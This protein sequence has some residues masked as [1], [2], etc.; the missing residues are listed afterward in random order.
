MEKKKRFTIISLLIA[1]AIISILMI[2]SIIAERNEIINRTKDLIVTTR[3]NHACKHLIADQADGKLEKGTAFKVNGRYFVYNGETPVETPS[4]PDTIEAVTLVRIKKDKAIAFLFQSDTDEAM[5]ENSGTIA[6]E[7]LVDPDEGSF[8]V[9]EYSQVNE[10]VEKYLEQVSYESTP[11]NVSY[12]KN[13]LQ[14]DKRY[15]LPL[16]LTIELLEGELTVIDNCTQNKY[17]TTVEKGPYTFYNITP[18]VGGEFYI[19]HEDKIVQRGHLRP[20][21]ALRMIYSDTPG[22]QNMRDLG[23]WP[24]DGGTIKYNILFRGGTVIDANDTDRNTWV[25]MLGIQHDV[26]LKTYDESQ[27]EGKEQYRNKSPLGD[28]VSFYQNDLTSPGSENK[29]NFEQAKDEMNGIINRIFDNAIAGEATYFHCLAGADRTGMVAVI[30][31][32]VLGVPLHEIDRDYELTSFSSVRERTE[33][34]YS[35]DIRILQKYPGLTFRDRCVEYLLDCGISL[36]KINAFRKAVIDGNPEEIV[37]K[38]STVTPGG[39]NLC[40]PGGEG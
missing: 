5:N 40:E 7:K 28:Q 38:F 24:C 22:L 34:A 13:F 37:E 19:L 20:T 39:S 25:K 31:E 8:P 11:R 23:G 27:F 10:A 29:Q 26:F 18:G 17:R 2:V 4:V 15:D 3:V 36:E 32:G 16:G 12:I 35:Y 9:Y 6:Y 1:I 33:S 30:L 14:S 21:G